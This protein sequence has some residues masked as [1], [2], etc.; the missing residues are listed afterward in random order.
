MHDKQVKTHTHTHQT[1]S[2]RKKQNRK[3]VENERGKKC[4]HVIHKINITSM[5]DE[6]SLIRSNVED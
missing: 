5:R 3:T 1:F 2:I 4:A 6:I